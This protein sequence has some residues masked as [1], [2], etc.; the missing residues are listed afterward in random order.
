MHFSWDMGGF[1]R[2]GVFLVIGG[3]SLLVVG[4]HLAW[5]G[6]SGVGVCRR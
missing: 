6:W 5:V 1:L 3:A 4:T 2:R